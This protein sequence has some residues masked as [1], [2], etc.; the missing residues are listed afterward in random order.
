ML[1]KVATEMPFPEDIMGKTTHLGRSPW[2]CPG[3]GYGGAPRGGRRDARCSR[4]RPEARPSRQRPRPRP[5]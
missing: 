4:E 5:R 2:R 3:T 1:V